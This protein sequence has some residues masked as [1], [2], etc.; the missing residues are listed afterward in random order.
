MC[1]FSLKK[2]QFKAYPYNF[3][4]VKDPHLSTLAMAFPLPVSPSWP[5]VRTTLPSLG[6]VQEEVQEVQEGV[7]EEGVAPEDDPAV[8]VPPP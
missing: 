4:F 8:L 1:E 7:Q 6:E 3:T 5:P 2:L